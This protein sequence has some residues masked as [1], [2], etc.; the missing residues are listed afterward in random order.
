[1][2]APD[3]NHD[4]A[5]P[6]GS[7]GEVFFAFLSLGLRSFGGPIA[8]LGYFRRAFVDERRWLDDARYTQLLALCQFLPGPASSQF[9]F[10]IGLMR[11][12]WRGAIAAFVG[13]T[14]PS[15]LLM[16]AFAWWTPYLQTAWGRSLLH[17]LKLVAVVVVAQAVHSMWR[18]LAPDGPRR[19]LAVVAAAFLL[20]QPENGMQLLVLAAAALLSPWVCRHVQAQGESSLDPGYGT[21]AGTML[22]VIYALLLLAAFTVAWDGGAL[23]RTGA[24]FYRAGALVFGGGHVVLP[25]LKQA[26]VEPGLID[27]NTFLAGYGAAQAVPGPMFSLAAFLG[28]HMVDRAGW[29]G[30][31]VALVAIFLPGFLLLG[32]AMP[33]WRSLSTR[34]HAVRIMAAIN[35]AVVG[36]LAAAFYNPV[37]TGTVHDAS[38]ILIALCG[39]VMLAVARQPAWVA[40]LWCVAATGVGT[41][42]VH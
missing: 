23:L 19:V 25:W 2:S 31:L 6:T 40:V 41:W 14:L 34:A 16:F 5:A 27:E 18:S 24:A 13:F 10:S 42:L 11:A 35:A 38:D 3:A 9:G 28:D 32:G 7:A 37:W 29:A 12:G 33:F 30:A 39:F 8:H 21:R 15:A 20:W 22:L 4:E 36:L 1:M 26:L 17:G